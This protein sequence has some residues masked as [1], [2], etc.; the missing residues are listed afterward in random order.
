[1]AYS[2]K[3]GWAV[4]GIAVATIIVLADLF[5]LGVYIADVCNPDMTYVEILQ[6]IFGIAKDTVE[7]TPTE[8]VETAGKIML[9]M[10]A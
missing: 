7:E 6:A 3:S 10:V 1:M 9:N 8:E 5:F 4:F 2:K